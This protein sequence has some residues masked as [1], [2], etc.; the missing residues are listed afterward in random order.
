M[1]KRGLFSSVNEDVGKIIVADVNKES[2]KKL[3]DDRAA[4]VKLIEDS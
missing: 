2:I 4:L 1:H 3:L